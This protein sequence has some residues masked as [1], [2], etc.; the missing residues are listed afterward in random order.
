MRLK[1]LQNAFPRLG[2]DT[3]EHTLGHVSKAVG[4]LHGLS[5]DA[6]HIETARKQVRMAFPVPGDGLPMPPFGV[7]PRAEPFTDAEK[8]NGKP[9]AVYIADLIICAAKL[10]ALCPSGPIDIEQAVTD[11]IEEKRNYLEQYRKPA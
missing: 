10:A 4:K 7:D 11:R 8:L 6:D 3:Y 1:E 5:G 2:V 9:A